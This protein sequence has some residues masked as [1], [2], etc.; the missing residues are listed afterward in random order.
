MSVEKMEEY[1]REYMESGTRAIESMTEA[2]ETPRLRDEA[3]AVILASG[4]NAVVSAIYTLYYQAERHR[5]EDYRD[6]PAQ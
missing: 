3:L 1:E 4:F 5:E 2:L 6:R